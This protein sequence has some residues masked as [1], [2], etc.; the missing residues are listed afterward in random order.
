MKKKKEE[1]DVDIIGGEGALT[2][3]EEKAVSE[4]FRQRNLA[5]GALEAKQPE[6][7]K[8][9]RAKPVGA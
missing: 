2:V 3:A 4:Y 5:K 6:I 9:E 8:S 1:L 7:K